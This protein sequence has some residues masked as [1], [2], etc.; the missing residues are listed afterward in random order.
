MFETT[1]RLYRT[2][3]RTFAIV[4]CS[5]CRLIRLSPQPAAAELGAYY[6]D[7]YW[8]SPEDKAVERW[9]EV[10]RRIVLRDHLGFVCR[11]LESAR[12]RG[13]V[14][15]VGCGGGLFLKM[16]AERGHRVLGL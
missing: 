4:E 7:T 5:R 2:T 12:A 1:D 11:A 15:D 13:P 14:L 6:P 9:E 16:L 3:D 8:F 10:Y